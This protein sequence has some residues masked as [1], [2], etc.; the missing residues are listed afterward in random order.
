MTAYKEL[1]PK[2]QASGMEVS[3]LLMKSMS[4]PAESCSPQHMPDFIPS[5]IYCRCKLQVVDVYSGFGQGYV[6]DAFE[7]VG[8]L[9]CKFA[10]IGWQSYCL[11]GSTTNAW[12]QDC[13]QHNLYH[14]AVLLRMRQS[15]MQSTLASSCVGSQ[16]WER[17]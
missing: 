14:S 7:K 12:T 6:Q 17:Q 1:I 3:L 10:V 13:S 9:S 2:W 8:Q 5:R 15:R 16:R 11:Q 4:V